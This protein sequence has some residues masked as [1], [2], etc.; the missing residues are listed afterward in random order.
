MEDTNM[1]VAD[2]ATPMPATDKPA[3][4]P[5]EMP[6]EEKKEEGTPASCSGGSCSG[7]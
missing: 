1:P 2:D 3:E 6:A 5:A 7:K 4:M